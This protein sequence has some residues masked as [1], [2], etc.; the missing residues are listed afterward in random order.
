VVPEFIQNLP[1]V[2]I[3]FAIL[4][5][6]HYQSNIKWMQERREIANAILED[7]KEIIQQRDNMLARQFAI[8][9]RQIALGEQRVAEQERTRGENHAM[10]GKLQEHMLRQDGFMMRVEKSLSAIE[11]YFANRTGGN[12]G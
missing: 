9:D 1:V 4:A 11:S 12:D 7:R 6:F 3:P 10:R 5:W 2:M 8:E